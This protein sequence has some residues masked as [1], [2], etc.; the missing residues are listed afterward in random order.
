MLLNYDQQFA[1]GVE[2]GE[3]LQ[4]IR[5][6]PKPPRVGET[7]HHY[8]YLRTKKARLLRRTSCSYV[9]AIRIAQAKAQMDLDV[10]IEGLSLDSSEKEEFAKRDGF[11]DFAAF[12]KHWRARPLPF[13]GQ[14]IHWR[15]G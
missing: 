3:L 12:V 6:R 9:E 5:R 11:E 7:L 14:V 15:L 4:T 13:E 2:S 1:R 10:E 8:E